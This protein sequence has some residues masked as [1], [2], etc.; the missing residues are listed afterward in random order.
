M[1]TIRKQEPL[2]RAYDQLSSVKIENKRLF[3]SKPYMLNQ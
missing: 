3:F 1:I 2:V